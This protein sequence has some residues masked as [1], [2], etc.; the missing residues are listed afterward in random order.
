M[1]GKVGHQ[2][3]QRVVTMRAQ[4]FTHAGNAAD[5]LQQTLAPRRA[6]LEGEGAIEL[7]WAIV[8][9][10]AKSFAAGSLKGGNLQLT[11]LENDNFPANRFEEPPDFLKQFVRNHAVEALAVVIDHPPEIPYVVLPSFEH[12]LVDIAL[13][14]F[15]VAHDGDHPPWW[16]LFRH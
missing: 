2:V 10:L 15:G 8:D 7:I 14:Q 12:G 11:V 5:I 4:Q 13:V 3:L 9:P 6:A 1:A 16:I